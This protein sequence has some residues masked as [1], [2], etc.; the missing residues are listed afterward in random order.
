MSNYRQKAP[1]IYTLANF[2]KEDN[3]LPIYFFFGEDQYT[4]DSAVKTV[5]KALEP[6]VLSEFDREVVNP[7]KNQKM[8]ELIDLVSSFPFGG[9]KKLVSVKNFEKFSDQ[10]SFIGYAK[11][12]ADF[13]HLII[14]YS[15]T[16]RDLGKEPF[17]TMLSNNYLF[18][19]RQLK[20]PELVNWVS[21]TAKRH[22][23]DMSYEVAQMMV[24]VVGIEK[25][26]IGMQ[27]EKL[28]DY[29]GEDG[30]VKEEHIKNSVSSTKEFSIFDLQDALG[31]GNKVKSIDVAINLL[32]SGQEITAI[33]GMIT[34]FIT[35]LAKSLELTRAN[36][37]IKSAASE[38]G[39]SEYYYK[40]CL[41]SRFLLNEK[42]L[43]NASR[44]LYNADLKLKTSAGDTKTVM[45]MM[46]SEMLNHDNL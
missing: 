41:K 29:L 13:A 35:T 40:N 16:V 19:A 5:E 44:A 26:L 6:K 45:L 15:G 37:H 32:D 28:S 42:R 27:I 20:G 3:F 38:A 39:V 22:K 8:S 43:L 1:S 2:L 4:I 17:S 7:E 21:K 18:E 31:A 24:D 11:N 12:P 25:G 46:I 9:G 14:S 10:K 23:L 30:I 34:K 33:I 36:T